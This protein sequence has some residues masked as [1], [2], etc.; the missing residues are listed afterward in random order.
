MLIRSMA[1]AGFYFKRPE[2]L[3]RARKAA[4]FIWDELT[5]QQDGALRL[6]GCLLRRFWCPGRWLF[7]RL[8]AGGRG[9]LGD[10]V[11]D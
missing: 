5:E 4:D 10:C 7:T 3:Q 6:K 2:W 1:D 8:C 9:L 11:E